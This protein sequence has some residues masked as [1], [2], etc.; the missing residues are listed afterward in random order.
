MAALIA[1]LLLL[2]APARAHE[3]PPVASEW[4]AHP[5]EGRL[6]VIRP[7][8][9]YTLATPEGRTVRSADFRGRVRVETFIYTR[10]TD[11]CP[12]VSAKLARLQA[13]LAARDLFG[14]RVVLA[15]ITLDPEHDTPVVLARH[16]AAFK[17]DPRGWLYLRGTPAQT[18]RLLAAYGGVLRPGSDLTHS[19]WIF[20]IDGESRVREIYSERLFDPDAVLADIAGLTA[21]AERPR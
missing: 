6:A 10:C 14:R 4:R 20:L 16:A 19:D 9:D 12:L 3:A 8:P 17:A 18:R 21:V 1:A 11:S 15:S 5:A 2:A 7:A 13:A